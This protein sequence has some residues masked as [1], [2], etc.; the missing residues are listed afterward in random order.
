MGV[1]ATV[2]FAIVVL[3][4]IAAFSVYWSTIYSVY[5]AAVTKEADKN[6]NKSVTEDTLSGEYDGMNDMV[7][8]V[9]RLR[10]LLLSRFPEGETKRFN[11]VF[12][13]LEWAARNNR[14]DREKFARLPGLLRTALADGEIDFRENEFILDNIEASIIIND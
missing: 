14:I 11:I 9:R 7:S 10:S 12:N 13:D 2:F 4:I 3:G 5:W 6:G 8:G 1:F